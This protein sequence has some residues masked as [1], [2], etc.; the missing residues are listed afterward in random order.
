MIFKKIFLFRKLTDIFRFIIIFTDSK[1]D[2]LWNFLILWIRTS[3]ASFCM[4]I[5]NELRMF[6]DVADAGYKIDIKRLSE[7]GKQLN[8]N[9]LNITLLSMLIPFFNIMQVFQRTIQYNNVRPM[10]L[11]HLSIID[12][13]EEMT[14]IEKREYLKNPTGLNA[15]LIPL[16]IEIKLLQASSIQI[17]DGNEHSEIFYETDKSL[18][19]IT[20]LKVTGAASKLTVE[21]QKKKVIDTWKIVI[22]GGIE[23]YGDKENFAKELLNNQHLNLNSNADETKENNTSPMNKLSISTQKKII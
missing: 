2:F 21:E 12:S 20:I 18:D 9:S 22:Q 19:N 5:T 3:I 17:N 8:P 1:G 15:V 13:L 11:N 16:K 10:V 23:K 6:K 4:E 14:E 7:I